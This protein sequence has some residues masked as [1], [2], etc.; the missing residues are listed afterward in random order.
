MPSGF[1]EE[2]AISAA[3]TRA[4]PYAA[5]GERVA[6][7]RARIGRACAVA[8]RDAS[9]VTLV[10]VTKTHPPEAVAAA[11]A[12]GLTDF[13]ENRVQE[14]VA[15]ASEL[16]GVTRGGRVRWHLIGPLQRNKTRD[17]V[18]YA[19][20]FHALDSLRLAEA[21]SRRLVAAERTLECF[22]QVNVSGEASKSGVAPEEAHALVDAAHALPGLCVVGLM[23]LAAPAETP[24][25]LEALVRP[26]LR[27]LRALRDAYAGPAPL[28]LLSM[29]MSGDL[30]V[31]VEEGATHVRIGTDLF[32]RR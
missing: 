22:V 18:A 13:G 6:A 9:E 10:A 11:Q 32:G 20:V 3:R 25:A 19:D 21:L 31:A 5:L 7:V 17:A 26:Q 23:T 12:A 4:L 16:P 24:A 27:Q 29:G 30:E 14:L 15:K 8:G 2:S 1:P 28:R